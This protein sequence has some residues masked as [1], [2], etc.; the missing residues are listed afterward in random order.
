MRSCTGI[1]L[2]AFILVTGVIIGTVIAFAWWAPA[3]LLAP[4]TA[5]NPTTTT[6]RQPVIPTIIVGGGQVT[7]EVAEADIAREMTAR[8]GGTELGQTPL[9]AISA[10]RFVVSIRNGQ[11]R[12]SG[13]ARAAGGKIP[14]EILT[15]ASATEAGRVA[16][17]VNEARVSGFN[18]PAGVRDRIQQAI[19]TEIDRQLGGSGV[20]VTSVQLDNGKLRVVGT[21]AA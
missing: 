12:I 15:R 16:V 9:G 7:V 1:A 21:R 17:E 5:P 11:M 19:Q 4:S 8:M 14:F 3:G 13:D 6:V 2:A 10:E 18:L 20:R